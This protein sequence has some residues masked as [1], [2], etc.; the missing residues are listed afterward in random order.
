LNNG[1]SDSLGPGWGLVTSSAIFGLAH[2]GVGN[3]ATIAQ[4]M[5]FGLYLGWLQQRNDYDIGEGVAIHF[6]W[7]FLVSLG[8]L[9]ER[10]AKEQEVQLLHVTWRF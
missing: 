2:E 5:L 9:K 3:Q 4:A 8:T 10:R 7:N 6:W 1:L